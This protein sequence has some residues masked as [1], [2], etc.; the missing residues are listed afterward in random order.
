MWTYLWCLALCLF[1]GRFYYLYRTYENSYLNELEQSNDFRER[2]FRIKGDAEKFNLVQRCI[3]ALHHP[4]P[5]TVEITNCTYKEVYTTWVGIPRIP[6]NWR[7]FSC[8]LMYGD[9]RI[10]D[11]PAGLGKETTIWPK[12]KEHL[13]QFFGDDADILWLYIEIYNAFHSPVSKGNNDTTHATNEGLSQQPMTW[14]IS[15]ISSSKPQPVSTSVELTQYRAGGDNSPIVWLNANGSPAYTNNGQLFTQNIYEDW[16]QK[17]D[18]GDFKDKGI[19]TA[20]DLDG[21]LKRI[22]LRQNENMEQIIRQQTE[23]NQLKEYEE[24]LYSQQ[25]Y[26]E[27]SDWLITALENMGHSSKKF[28]AT[29]REMRKQCRYT[30]AQKLLSNAY[31]LFHAQKTKRKSTNT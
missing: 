13:R 18:A 28:N 3:T 7:T 5:E 20:E 27:F 1:C 30:E 8:Y 16:E 15:P 12:N 9:G 31:E 2:Y 17:A 26:L 19:N 25:D 22:G 14:A 21:W 10:I 11:S 24:W 29:L 23:L 4:H 6:A